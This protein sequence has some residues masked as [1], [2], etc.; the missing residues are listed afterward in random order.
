MSVILSVSAA[1]RVTKHLHTYFL[2][3]YIIYSQF[4]YRVLFTLRKVIIWHWA[5][6]CFYGSPEWTIRSR[7]LTLLL[8]KLEML[9]MRSSSWRGACGQ[10]SSLCSN[11]LGSCWF[12]THLICVIC[13]WIVCLTDA[14]SALPTVTNCCW[15][16]FNFFFFFFSLGV[17]FR[18]ET[19]GIEKREVLRAPR[20]MDPS[21]RGT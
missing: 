5:L 15:C 16:T 3:V 2:T 13:V 10:V 12:T 9:R 18:A 19:A 8:S 14:G 21:V 1:F 7:I 20:E 11:R 4:N 17:I 6:P